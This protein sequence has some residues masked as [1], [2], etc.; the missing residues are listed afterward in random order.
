MFLV[1]QGGLEPPATDLRPRRKEFN[2]NDFAKF[3]K[4]QTDLPNPD[5]LL[6]DSWRTAARICEFP[7]QLF[8]ISTSIP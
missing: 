5:E 7:F 6:H 4:F 8:P 3:L 2:P 1:R